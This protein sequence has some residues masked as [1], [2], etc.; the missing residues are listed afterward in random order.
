MSQKMKSVSTVEN[1]IMTSKILK[2]N[3]R[4]Y[5]SSVAL[6][7]MAVALP[8]S[9]LTVLLLS[10]G[11][12]IAQIATIQ[13]AYSCAILLME[14]PSGAL[15][16]IFDRRILFFISQLF[17]AAFF[18][19]VFFANSFFVLAF[20][21]FLYGISSALD[22]GTLD[23]DITN[24]IKFL[25]RDVDFSRKRISMFIAKKNQVELIS[26]LVSSIVGSILYYKVGYNIY[27]LSTVLAFL[28]FITVAIKFKKISCYEPNERCRVRCFVK[29]VKNQILQSFY[30]LKYNRTLKYV[31]FL[32]GISQIFFQTHYQLW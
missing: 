29:E 9:V 16:D 26:M 7:G 17:L 14:F 10:K 11:I 24:A 12:T 22:T 1:N 2:G 32:N 20:A 6:T 19:T 28:S 30:E 27:I 23:S 5:Y 18:I 21:W 8:H 13:A 15:A 25:N 31:L 4:A 3:M